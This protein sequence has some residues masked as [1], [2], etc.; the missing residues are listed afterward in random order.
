MAFSWNRLYWLNRRSLYFLKHVYEQDR[1]KREPVYRLFATKDDSTQIKIYTRTGDK[2]M[3]S[4]FAGKR[5]P[6]DHIIFDA[7]GANDQLSST[8]GIAREFCTDLNDDTTTRLKEIQCILQDVG[9]HIATPRGVAT[10]SKLAQTAFNEK[11]VENLEKWI[12]ELNE[13]LPPLTNFILPSGGRAASMLHLARTV[14]REAERRV[15]PL[16]RD[17]QVEDSVA[18]YLNRLSDFLFMAARHVA[19]QQGYNEEIYIRQD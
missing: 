14:C 17:N 4:N 15:T 9:S 13:N 16:V 3:S 6:K 19:K 18:K 1:L 2:G 12:D 7:L 11:H 8:I 10:E 5:L